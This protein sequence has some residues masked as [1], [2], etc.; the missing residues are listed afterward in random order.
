MMWVPGIPW[1]FVVF[2]LV[3]LLISHFRWPH[4]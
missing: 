3:V 1:G 4:L 2:S